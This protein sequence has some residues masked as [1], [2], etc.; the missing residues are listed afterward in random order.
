MFGWFRERRRRKILQTPFPET[1]R[2]ILREMVLHYSYLDSDEKY[3]LEQLVQIFIA[4]KNFEGCGGLEL[5]EE[6][7][8]VVA[9]QACLLVLGLPPCQY[10]QL[11]SVLVYPTT[12]ALPPSRLSVFAG[13][14][15]IVPDRQ[16]ILGMASLHGP[17]ILVW[18]AVQRGARHPEQGHNVVYHEFAHILDMRDGTADGTPELHN[19]KLYR[20]WVDICSKEFFRLQQDAERGRKTF[21]DPYGAVHEAEFFAVATEFFFDRPIRMAREHAELYMVLSAYYRQDTAA[22]E[23]RYR[24]EV[25]LRET[26]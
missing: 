14:P 1:W 9:T 3:R 7:K 22:R 16:A 13:P 8:V 2:Q 24:R 15:M 10:L 5:S 12:V 26:D 6:I 23:R 25:A 11:D 19:R 20:K 18:D 4:E 21:L 17:V